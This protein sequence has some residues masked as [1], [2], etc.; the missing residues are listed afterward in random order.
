MLVSGRTC[1]GGMLPWQRTGW[2]FRQLPLAGRL[3]RMQRGLEC[4][5][6]WRLAASPC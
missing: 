1:V 4:S 5:A 3:R 6:G 2:R